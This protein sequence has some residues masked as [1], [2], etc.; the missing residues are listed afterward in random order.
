MSSNWV[1]DISHWPYMNQSTVSPPMA[2]SLA[3]QSAS[4][5]IEPW[6][7]FGHP[8]LLCKTYLRA[9]CVIF[10]PHKD[11]ITT[12]HCCIGSPWKDMCPSHGVQ[13]I[14]CYGRSPCLWN[15]SSIC[16]GVRWLYSLD[17]WMI[18]VSRRSIVAYWVWWA[19][20]TFKMKSSLEL[21]KLS[22]GTLK[23]C[24]YYLSYF[25]CSFQ[26]VAEK[27]QTLDRYSF[28]NC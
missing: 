28:P 10:S 20:N 26:L 5:Q 18:W 24:A 4:Q 21:L 15:T 25:T 11:T 2:K 22:Q 23:R 27:Y 12:G 19:V 7:I 13:H 8:L 1:A 16:T 9:F 3:A 14:G 17:Q 6:Q